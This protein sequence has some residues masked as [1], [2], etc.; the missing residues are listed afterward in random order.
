MTHVEQHKMVLDL[1][2]VSKKM[3]TDEVSAFEMMFKRD[4]DDEDLDELTR[5][6][7][8]ALHSKYFPKKSKKDLDTLWKKFTKPEQNQ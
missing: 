4:K 2:N 8:E 5:R 3:S 7:L 1:Q 6:K